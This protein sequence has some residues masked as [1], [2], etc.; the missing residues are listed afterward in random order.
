MDEEKNFKFIL[1]S[2]MLVSG[3]KMLKNDPPSNEEKEQVV[4]TI[5]SRT[6]ELLER[7]CWSGKNTLVNLLESL[8][9]FRGPYIQCDELCFIRKEDILA[10]ILPK[11]EEGLIESRKLKRRKTT[12]RVA[13][14]T[15]TS[16]HAIPARL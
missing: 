15:Y 11:K 16:S 5:R 12:T 6:S 9:Q 1:A 10:Q 8:E 3:L 2:A 13:N 4:Q 14:T 7:A